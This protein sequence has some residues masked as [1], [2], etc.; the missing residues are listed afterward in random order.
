MTIKISLF[1]KYSLKS[2]TLY[3]RTTIK[4][5]YYKDQ[6]LFYFYQ[7]MVSDIFISQINHDN[8]NHLEQKLLKMNEY[9]QKF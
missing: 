1:W 9:S 3:F 2:S 6:I 7:K 4:P 8:I 5:K